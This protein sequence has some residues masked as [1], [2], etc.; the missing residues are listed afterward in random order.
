MTTIEHGAFTEVPRNYLPADGL[1]ES[2]YGSPD[3]FSTIPRNPAA[4]VENIYAISV[5]EEFPRIE[6][7]IVKCR[8]GDALQYAWFVVPI[9]FRWLRR[10]T[11]ASKYAVSSGS[12]SILGS[13]LGVG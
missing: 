11:S 12:K 7:L 10:S 5:F 8:R 2:G 3:S 9:D 6:S 4:D 1:H 13:N